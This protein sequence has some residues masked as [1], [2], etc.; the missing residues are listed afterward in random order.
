MASNPAT[1][2]LF[3]AAV[4][5]SVVYPFCLPNWWGAGLFDALRVWI[6]WRTIFFGSFA[7]AAIGASLWYF[8]SFNPKPKL[9]T[10]EFLVSIA[11]ILTLG[12]LVGIGHLL[13]AP[14]WAGLKV[15]GAFAGV[16]TG[17]A[18]LLLIRVLWRGSMTG[19]SQLLFFAG[20]I[21]LGIVSV[22]GII[23]M[24]PPIYTTFHYT[25]N[26][27]AHAHLALGSILMIVLAAG[28]SQATVLTKREFSGHC[29]ALTGSG[30]FVAGILMLF[31]FQT[32]AGVLQATAFIN[33][34]NIT[35]WLPMF[36]WLQLGVLAGGL[37]A[38]LG[39]LG[40]GL[41]LA[42]NL[43]SPASKA[44]DKGGGG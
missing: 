3:L 5:P 7:M 20:L 13:D 21:G 19:A 27:T 31:I 39:I 6:S 17:A 33:G 26:T 12:P 28:L 2:F 10:G 40:I 41:T 24:F 29:H 32:L 15:I 38:F 36:R 44:I 1:G 18:F 43:A 30:F 14:I 42:A 37:L 8:G 35:D 11:I 23:L 25:S 16:V 34:L 9:P 22:Q 4:L